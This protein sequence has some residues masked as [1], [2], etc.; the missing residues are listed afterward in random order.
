MVVG[1][2][3]SPSLTSLRGLHD[4]VAASPADGCTSLD[5]AGRLLGPVPLLKRQRQ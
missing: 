3:W 1:A 2:P 5:N 4:V